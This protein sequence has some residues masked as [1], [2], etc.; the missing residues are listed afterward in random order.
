[1]LKR[2]ATDV[3][4]PG[5]TPQWVTLLP[6]VNAG[7]NGLATVLLIVGYRLIRAG[8]RDG[9]KRAM[10]SAFATSI[11]FLGCY[12]LYHFALEHYTGNPSKSF[13]GKGFPRVVY[14]GILFS[15]IVLAAVVPVM[16]LI[17]LFRAWKQ[18]WTKH[19]YIAKMTY[20]I[21]LYVSVT[22]VIIYWMLYHSPWSQA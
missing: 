14:L 19:K 3:P 1:M 5:S 13:P 9:H 6:A 18:Q 2:K 4:D 8:R 17:T 21:W 10:L 20:P 12:L 11:L 22:G 7:L 15:H 16:A